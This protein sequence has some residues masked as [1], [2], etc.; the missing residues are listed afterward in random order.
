MA[1]IERFNKT[2]LNKIKKYMH[3]YD[4]LNYIDTL[5]VLV[6][7]YNRTVHSSTQQRPIDIYLHNKTPIIDIDIKH[8]ESA[9]RVRD[10]ARYKLKRKT[11][12]KKGFLPIF[13]N[14]IYNY[15][16]KS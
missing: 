2:L 6:Q 13:I 12:D 4:T 9:F 5:P 15:Q 7:N 14:N 16:C 3:H 1:M 11:F 10:K 8:L